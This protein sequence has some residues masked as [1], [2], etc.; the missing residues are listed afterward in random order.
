MQDVVLMIF[1]NSKD[2]LIENYGT[3]LAHLVLYL[4]K[5]FEKEPTTRV[6][7][8]SQFTDYLEMIGALLA[9]NEISSSTVE[10]YVVKSYKRHR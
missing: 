5:L 4:K 9:E 6:I 10:G 2:F 3:K 8:F 1:Q 7:V